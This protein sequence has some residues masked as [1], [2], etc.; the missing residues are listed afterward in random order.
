MNTCRYQKVSTLKEG[1]MSKL[2]LAIDTKYSRSV[3]LK[4]IK[5]NL[6]KLAT[7]SEA[8][9]FS[10]SLLREGRIGQML[11]HPNI[12]RAYDFLIFDGQPTVVMEFI[13]GQSL[14]NMIDGPQK[15]NLGA[16][17]NLIRQIGKGV[18]FAISRG[19]RHFDLKPGNIMVTGDW[20]AIIIDFGLGWIS[21][22]VQTHH[23]PNF[24][25]PLYTSPEQ[26]KRKQSRL[27]DIFNLG[28]LTFELLTGYHPF[29]GGSRE[30]GILRLSKGDYKNPPNLGE[31]P[32]KYEK[33]VRVFDKVLSPNLDFRYQSAD[34]FFDELLQ[35]FVIAEPQ[36]WI[37]TDHFRLPDKRFEIIS[38]MEDIREM[39]W[40]RFRESL[41][42]DPDINTIDLKQMDK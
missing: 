21:G 1:G 3:V 22:D 27:A 41:Q 15:Y 8:N 32:I 7:P 33:W 12:V 29:R 26:L 30:E 23:Q 10:E 42:N 40:D 20:R 31:L 37:E 6:L 35:V 14:D 34:H 13:N 19:I 24:L 5:T 17:V 9:S 25:T 28:I 18:D 2:I 36:K 4:S 38:E 16:K 11:K 39:S